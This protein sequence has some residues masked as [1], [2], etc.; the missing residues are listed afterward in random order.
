MENANAKKPA[1]MFTA[2]NRRLCPV[3]GK[4]SYSRTGEHPQCAVTRADAVA[5][6]AQK[7]ARDIAAAE[8]LAQQPGECLPLD[9]HLAESQQT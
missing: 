3:C 1:P 8:L 7:Q 5:K 9:A 2:P 6:V 4:A